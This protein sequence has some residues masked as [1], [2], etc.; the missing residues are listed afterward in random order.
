VGLR[1]SATAVAEAELCDAIKIVQ[2]H[3]AEALRLVGAGR[4]D[5]HLALAQKVLD[6]AQTLSNDVISL[7]DIYQMGP[8]AVRNASIAR[9]TAKILEDHGWFIRVQRG[10]VVGGVHRREAWRV[11]RG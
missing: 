2:Y 3:A 8:Q 11:V 7:T 4:N 9:A 1:I 10:A 6:W 5:P